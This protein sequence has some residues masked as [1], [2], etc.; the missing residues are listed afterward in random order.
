[1]AAIYKVC[2]PDYRDPNPEYKYEKGY[3]W[4]WLKESPRW[5]MGKFIEYGWDVE[6]KYRSTSHIEAWA[7]IT[8]PPALHPYNN[9]SFTAYLKEHEQ[10]IHEQNQP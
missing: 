2:N 10:E 3:V 6:G 8:P 1:M 5:E 7:H 9:P 4:V